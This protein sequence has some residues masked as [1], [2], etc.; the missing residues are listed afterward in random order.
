MGQGAKIAAAMVG[1]Y[2]LGRKKK[3]KLAI[4]VGLW[5]AG[6]K[7]D[8]NPQQLAKLARQL[9]DSPQVAQLRE[10]AQGELADV[11]RQAAGALVN[12]QAGRLA[13]TLSERTQRLYEP[14]SGSD[15]SAEDAETE[16]GDERAEGTDDEPDAETEETASEESSKPAAKRGT[17]SGT[18]S[19]AQSQSRST[20]KRG[21]TRSGS[22]GSR[23]G[24]AKR[25]PAKT[26]QG[27]PAPKGES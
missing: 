4:A 26:R 27:G 8:I 6:K 25:T 11:G 24:S 1:G 5:L 3:A 2:L 19:R 16:A 18:A 9:G 22:G 17:R 10:Q 20:A 7:L 23:Q 13:D 14:Q 15:E 21:G 12:R